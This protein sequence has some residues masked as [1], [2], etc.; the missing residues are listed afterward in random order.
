MDYFLRK[1]DFLDQLSEGLIAINSEGIIN[2][3]NDKAKDM[4]GASRQCNEAHP[5]GKLEA[6]DIVILAFT[7][8]GRDAGGIS[9]E[10]LKDLGI[11]L[12]EIE[13]GTTLLAVGQYKSNVTGKIKLKGPD[14]YLDKIV[15]QD[16]FNDIEFKSKIDFA[17]R[18]VE[19]QVFDDSYRY[20]YNNYFNHFVI[21]NPKHR[22]VKFYQMGGYTLWKEDLKDL[23]SGKKFYEKKIGHNEIELINC[24]LTNFHEVEE[25]I[26][27]FIECAEGMHKGYQGKAGLINGINVISTLQPIYRGNK[28]VGAYLLLNDI[29]RLQIAENQRN[30]AYRKLKQATEALEDVKKYEANFH[31]YIGSS[32]KIMNIKKL[33]YK[34]SCFR[35]TVLILGESGTGKSLLARAIHDASDRKKNPF[36]EV[37]LNSVPDS[38]IESELFGYEKGAFTGASS[39]GK[40]GYFDLAHQGTIFLD[41]IGDLKKEL[42]VK[43]LHVIQN[44]SFYRVGGNK[45]VKVDVRIIVATNRNLEKDVVNGRFRE[46]LYYRINVFPIKQLPLRERIEDLYEL[47]EYILPKICYNVGTVIKA[48]SAEAYEKMKMYH[49]PGNV[50]ELENVLERAVTLCDGKT[51]LS[52]H[53]DVRIT[54]KNQLTDEELLKPLKETLLEMELDIIKRVMQHTNGN[55]KQTMAFLK[56]KKTNLYDKLKLIEW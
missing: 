43:L 7:S 20:Y 27:E 1:N 45:E 31:N 24:H 23:M 44:K 16:V 29:R 10:D 12:I 55:K 38:L 30:I 9:H 11:E 25:I 37:N 52:E 50:R 54:Q 19:I 39:K 5:S 56:I 21:V 6:G 48:I 2:T 28:V 49:W 35:S 17:D 51:L 46:D 42:Q 15:M 32:P 14:H 8:F 13:K 26:T 47:V 18:F 22:V 4:L 3:Y 36:I 40:K 53:I 41:E 34:A 33:A